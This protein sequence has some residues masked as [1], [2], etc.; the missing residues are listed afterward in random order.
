MTLSFARVRYYSVPE[1]QGWRRIDFTIMPL[2]RDCLSLALPPCRC[3]NPKACSRDNDTELLQKNPHNPGNASHGCKAD[4]SAD[5]SRWEEEAKKQQWS[6]YLDLQCAEGYTGTLCG[7]CK[8]GFGQT[9]AFSCDECAGVNDDGSGPDKWKIGAMIAA[10]GILFVLCILVTS[11]FGLRSGSG[12]MDAPCTGPWFAQLKFTDVAKAFIMYMQYTFGIIAKVPVAG[13]PFLKNIMGPIIAVWQRSNGASASLDCFLQAVPVSAELESG[14][15]RTIA[16]L[17]INLLGFVFTFLAAVILHCLVYWLWVKYG[18]GLLRVIQRRS[19]WAS[20]MLYSVASESSSRGHTSASSAH[21][22]CDDLGSRSRRKWPVPLRGLGQFMVIALLVSIFFWYTTI[23]RVAISF[24]ACVEVEV[25]GEPKLWMVDMR[26]VCPRLDRGSLQHK[27]ALAA[28]IPALIVTIGMPVFVVVLLLT[29]ATWRSQ[30][31]G[32]CLLRSKGFE[33]YFSFMYSDYN[34]D[35]DWPRIACGSTWAPAVEKEEEEK[36]ASSTRARVAQALKRLKQRII[37]CVSEISWRIKH[38]IR[39]VWDAVIHLHSLV[40]VML[41]IY[42][43]LLHEYYQ[44]LLLSAACGSYLMLVLWLRPF[45]RGSQQLQTVSMGVLVW[46]CSLSLAFVE[47]NGLSE[48]EAKE[49]TYSAIEVAAACLII[50]GNVSYLLFIAFLVVATSNW[51][52]LLLELWSLGAAAA[53]GSAEGHSSPSQQDLELA[54]PSP[55]ISGQDVLLDVTS[56]KD[57]DIGPHKRAARSDQ[58]VGIRGEL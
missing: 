57:L 56:S 40:L 48:R 46:T 18:L 16:R 13:P 35:P 2:M 24:F 45:T 34:Y 8:K 47:P 4:G 43:M 22:L 11:W 21:V 20:D 7:V 44:L 3:P 52:S 37:Q 1:T 55:W 15:T 42:G 23:A 28:G 33:A 53:G 17:L 30:P 27:W 54:G 41:S 10:F 9:D 6:D 39:L 58:S 36:A 50:A 38:G 51:K 49:A 12:S 14:P 5:V 29:A 31:G 26:H 19:S 32:E 25:C